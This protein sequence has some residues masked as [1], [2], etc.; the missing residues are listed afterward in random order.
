MLESPG[1]LPRRVLEHLNWELFI[2]A[3]RGSGYG[4]LTPTLED[5]YEKHVA[6]GDIPNML[7]FKY[8]ILESVGQE[9][10]GGRLFTYEFNGPRSPH[11]YYDV[12][13]M[14]FPKNPVM[15]R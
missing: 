13:A 1:F 11:D 9:R 6:T 8:Q 4:G 15:T 10:V 7:F 14:R 2:K 3:L 12:G 5:F